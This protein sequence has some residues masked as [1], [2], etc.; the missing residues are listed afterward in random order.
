MRGRIGSAA[1]AGLLLVAFATGC[2]GA[3]GQGGSGGAAETVVVVTEERGLTLNPYSP[4]TSDR[5]IG[6]L[7]LRGLFA[8]GPDGGPEPDL[9]VEVPT[10]AN[11]GLGDGGRTV[12]YR[13]TEDAEWSDGTPLTSRD[14]AF[15]IRLLADGR[16]TDDPAEDM[17]VIE[18]VTAP[19]DRTVVV[20]MSAPDSV[21]AWR[22]APYVLPEHVLSGSADPARD[23]YWQAPVV[24]GPYEV[25]HA[26]PGGEVDLAPRA[27]G[28]PSLTI[29]P[30][31]DSAEAARAFDQAA[32]AVWLDAPLG[33]ASDAESLST[34]WGPV[35]KRLAFDT[36]P[37][38][39]WNDVGL[40]RAVAAMTST[41]VPPDLPEAA[42]PFGIAPPSRSRPDTRAAARTFEAAGYLFDAARGVRMKEGKRL[43]LFTGTH[44]MTRED[45][46][47]TQ[48]ITN[49]WAS[50]GMHG[51][52]GQGSTWPRTSWMEYGDVARG[53]KPAY[54]LAIPEGRPWGW[55]F[56]FV[57]GDHP[58]W[59]R[60]W[61]LNFGHLDDPEVEEAYRQARSAPDP[62]A[63]KRAMQRAGRRLYDLAVVI[64]LWPLPER[65]LSKGVRGVKAWPA[66]DEAL[67]QAPEWRVGDPAAAG[68]GR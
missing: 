13:V 33:P 11:G 52:I 5:R 45:A 58:S 40:R 64:D 26:A 29:S 48:H 14:V 19:D 62:E 55:A 8:V 66:P 65:V 32:A 9:A 46:A 43:D 2:A 7:L 25:E 56:Q 22:L 24:S 4:R 68:D 27:P 16:L 21:L 42:Y 49:V 20:R 17:S 61:G 38:Q 54:Y 6:R 44:A 23:S 50:S 51:V 35:W 10:V 18:S 60:P 67:A 12:T 47:V 30:H 53:V 57:A 3:P 28:A 36:R 39:R 59:E 34:T 1:L 15:T 63:S 41:T 31:R 37:G